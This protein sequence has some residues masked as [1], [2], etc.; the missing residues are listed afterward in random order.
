MYVSVYIYIYTHTQV[1]NTRGTNAEIIKRVRN[2]VTRALTLPLFYAEREHLA[3]IPRIQLRHSL[4]VLVKFGLV[5][6]DGGVPMGLANLAD[7]LHF[8]EPANFALVALLQ[9]C[10]VCV[11][12]SV[13][14]GVEVFVRLCVYFCV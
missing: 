1:G 10:L 2:S 12:S 11:R 3:A 6:Q 7:H 5:K 8:T 9:V 14:A 4:D 13:H